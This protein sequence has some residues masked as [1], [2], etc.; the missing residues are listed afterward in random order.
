MKS[1][2]FSEPVAT[3]REYYNSN[4]ADRFY[5][6]VWGGEDIHIGIYQSDEEPIFAAS[7]RT[8][9]RMADLLVPLPSSMRVLDVGAG[10]GGSARYLTRRFGVHVTCLNLSEVQNH[11]NRELNERDGLAERIDVVDGDFEALPFAENSFEV[12]WSQDAILHS[13]N[14]PK[15]LAEIDRVLKPGGQVIFTDPM[16]VDDCPTALLR[17]VLDRIHL[18]SLGSPGFYR[19]QAQQL[20]WQER[21]W[22]DLSP[23]L[24]R[25]YAS[26]R[27]EICRRENDLRTVC[28]AA[29]LDRMK[30]GLQH[31]VD[32]GEKGRL[33]WGIFLFQK[34]Q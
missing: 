11:R 8:V 16:M 23:Q 19:A 21:A 28:D 5:A 3:A 31:W 24:P 13:G 4:D 10:Y 20:G 30:I 18:E 22:H 32:A 26:V 29:Y 17:P 34:R 2:T 1:A 14:R 15:V 27:A 6:A 25:H 9:E 33:K 12:I 7:R